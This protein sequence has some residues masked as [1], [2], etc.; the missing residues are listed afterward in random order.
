MHELT[1]AKQRYD[2]HLLWV[3]TKFYESKHHFGS[4]KTMNSMIS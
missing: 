3:A 4:D 1:V 2:I